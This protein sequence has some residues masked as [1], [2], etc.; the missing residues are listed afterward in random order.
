VDGSAKVTANNKEIAEQIFHQV[1][2][3]AHRQ[4]IKIIKTRKIKEKK[5][6]K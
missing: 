5:C 2:S 6:Q 4:P 1:A 3:Q